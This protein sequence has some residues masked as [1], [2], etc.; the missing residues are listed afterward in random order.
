M[1]KFKAFLTGQ[2]TEYAV[3]I[4]IYMVAIC[5]NFFSGNDLAA[6]LTFS[7]PF[8]ILS[9][10][11]FFVVYPIGFY[12]IYFCSSFLLGSATDFAFTLLQTL[13]LAIAIF[14]HFPFAP[15]VFANVFAKQS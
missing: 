2:A 1:N 15:L 8:A 9:T 13:S 14:Y 6:N 7:V 12:V 3:I 11:R 5:G 4:S 10:G